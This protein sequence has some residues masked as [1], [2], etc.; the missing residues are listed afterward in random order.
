MTLRLHPDAIVETSTSPLLA[1]HQS[2][3]RVRLGDIAEVKNGAAFKSAFFNSDED[4]V[5]LIRIRDVGAD[6]TDT[7][8]SGEY[9]DDYLVAPG[10]LVVGMDG[11]FR[12][13]RWPGPEAL[14]NQR[15][16]RLRVRAPHLYDGAFLY[17][18]LGGY[19]DAVHAVTSAVT[20]KHLSSK[21]VQQ[22]PLPL[23]PLTEQRR[24]VSAIE[25]HFTRIEAAVASLVTA[26][27]RLRVYDRA[28]RARAFD[29]DWPVV[30]LGDVAEIRG[31]IQKQPKRRPRDNPYP[32]LRVANVY[33]NRLDLEEIHEVELFD[34][35][36]EQYRLHD[37]DLLVVE[38][39][40]S[41]SQIGRSAM[42]GDEIPECVHQNHLIRVRPGD[43]L[44]PRFLSYFWNSP[45][46][47]DL[48]M[49]VASSTSGL[50]TLSTGKLRNVPVPVP[51]L[52]QQDEVVAL[53]DEHDSRVANLQMALDLGGR[54]ATV[55]KTATLAD[56]FA[57]RLEPQDPGDEP[58]QVLLDRLARQSGVRAP[59]AKKRTKLGVTS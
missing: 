54:R 43:A 31:G 35:E 48:L 19:L 8:Y 26:A 3:N 32:F 37:G 40:G 46:T 56:A 52:A 5:P 44:R 55:L 12:V 4:G 7:W 16:C 13:A 1:K 53:L 10:E 33:R 22:L 41:P 28:V 17:Y 6:G 47:A 42:W 14:L 51:T 27:D 23:P 34:G 24:I 30:D 36:I 49:S 39:N 45:A 20:V 9:E 15:V 29:Q 21:T 11:D 59:A 2:W 50:Y 38:G 58:A 25:E 18:V 57:G